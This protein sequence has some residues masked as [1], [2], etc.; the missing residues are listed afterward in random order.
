MW[1]VRYPGRFC[2][3]SLF[4]YDVAT[5][6]PNLANKFRA[7]DDIWRLADAVFGDPAAFGS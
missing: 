7:N 3:G 2:V 6:K 1:V 5:I 4:Q